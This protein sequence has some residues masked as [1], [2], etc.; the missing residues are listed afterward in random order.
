M[1]RRANTA[2]RSAVARRRKRERGQEGS[3]SICPAQPFPSATTTAVCYYFTY[4]PTRR[5]PN[6]VRSDQ[7]AGAAEPVKKVVRQS[8]P[9]CPGLLGRPSGAAAKLCTT[10]FPARHRVFHCLHQA[11]SRAAGRADFAGPRE[12]SV[13]GCARLAPHRLRPFLLRVCTAHGAVA[14]LP[15]LQRHGLPAELCGVGRSRQDHHVR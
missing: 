13:H 1:E 8:G 2:R 9:A 7:R 15:G 12:W 14:G 10:A 5:A 3:I 4:L 11:T 6:G